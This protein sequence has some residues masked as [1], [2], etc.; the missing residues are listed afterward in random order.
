MHMRKAAPILAVAALILAASVH[1]LDEA[2]A[3]VH[4][5]ADAKLRVEGEL[6][7]EEPIDF[8]FAPEQVWRHLAQE[9]HLQT[10][11]RRQ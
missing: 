11:A 8:L 6:M 4:C 9:Q 10:L 7:A 1:A 3:S 5:A 2:G